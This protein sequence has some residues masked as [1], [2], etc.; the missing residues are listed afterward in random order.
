MTA[1][2]IAAPTQSPTSIVSSRS[3]LASAAWTVTCATCTVFVARPVGSAVSTTSAG[4][5]PDGVTESQGLLEVA[6]K[7]VA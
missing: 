4:L 7:E 6:V 3:T 2:G 5:V 1:A